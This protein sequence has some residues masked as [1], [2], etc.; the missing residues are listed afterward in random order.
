MP[1]PPEYVIPIL[2]IGLIRYFRIF[3]KRFFKKINPG[4]QVYSRAR[5]ILRRA[6]LRNA[7]KGDRCLF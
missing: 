6:L 2:L 1:L 7:R 4:Y 5:L 3:V